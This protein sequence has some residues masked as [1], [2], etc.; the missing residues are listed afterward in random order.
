MDPMGYAAN[1][2]N[3]YRGVSNNAVNKLD[4]LGLYD[5]DVHFFM[6]YYSLLQLDL[7]SAI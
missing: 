1:D 6:T 2:V 5:E 3:L 4:S 7:T